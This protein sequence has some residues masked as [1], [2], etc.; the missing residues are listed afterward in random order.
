MPWW[1]IAAARPPCTSCV[2]GRACQPPPATA[3]AA[4]SRP[5]LDPAATGG[6]AYSARATVQGNDET[7]TLVCRRRGCAGHRRHST[8]PAPEPVAR[9]SV[10]QAAVQPRRCA[11][12]CAVGQ[13]RA[14]RCPRTARSC[15]WRA[16]RRA[17]GPVSAAKRQRAIAS[18]G[19]GARRRLGRRQ[20]AGRCQLAEHPRR[21]GLCLRGDR[22]FNGQRAGA[23][24][25]SGT[26]GAPGAGMAGPAR[27]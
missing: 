4:C 7:I 11:D 17:P 9:R 26:P 20:P 25:H 5:R 10:D 23:L 16:S 18:A 12:Q 2:T 8:G 14:G 15:L 27:R 24:S 22:L 19:V 1:P 6:R 13:A 21:A 3:S